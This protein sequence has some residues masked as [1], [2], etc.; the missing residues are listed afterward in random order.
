MQDNFSQSQIV[1][2]PAV[3]SQHG[4]VASQHIVAAQAGAEILAKG[5]DAI[6]AAV[7]TSMALG[8]VEPWMSGLAAGGCMIVWRARERKAYAVN[9]GMRSPLGL[10]P[11][12]YPLSGQGVASDL[13]PWQHVVDDRNVRGATAVAVPGLV[14]GMGLAHKT[15]GTLPWEQLVMPAADL[16]EK[17]MLADWYSALLTGANARELTQD[18]DTA[19]YFLQDGKWPILGGWTSVEQKRLN[20]KV[21]AQTLRTLAQEGPD[22]FYQGS[23]AQ[24]LVRDIQAKGGCLSMEDLRTYQAQ[25]VEPLV[26]EYA[27]GRVFAA[28]E[29]TGGPTYLQALQWLVEHPQSKPGI[30]EQTYAAF[31]RALANAFEHRLNAM[32]DHES[33]KAPG[34]TTHF[35]VVDCEGNMCSVTQTLLSIFGSRV[36][37]PSTGLLLNNGIMWF[38]PEPGKPNSLAPGKRCLTNYCPVIGQ[39]ANGLDFA[40]GASGGRKILGSVLQISQFMMGH[41]LSLEAAFEQARIDVSSTT[42]IIADPK[43]GATTLQA[44]ETVLPVSTARRHIYPYA[45]ACPAGVARQDGWNYGCTETFTPWGDAVAADQLQSQD[46]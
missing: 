12:D 37:S 40:I 30:N 17:G 41:G 19:A 39:S 11:A 27:Q 20:Q 9:F 5:G 45:Y 1:R 14:A 46:G 16:A 44:L 29:L 43:L 4:V 7:A 35:S 33:P 25:I 42:K 10:N 6:D 34:S 2:K 32:G 15:F 23:I 36:T 26:Y 8:V 3:R 18:A 24:A 13:F 28:P 22:A 31:A 38:D 21:L